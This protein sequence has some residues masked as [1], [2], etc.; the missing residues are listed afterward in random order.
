MVALAEHPEVH[1]LD[2][3]LVLRLQYL[4][5]GT[6]SQVSTVCYLTEAW[7]CL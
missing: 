5:P 7:M 1:C 6:E 3:L 2:E 4:M